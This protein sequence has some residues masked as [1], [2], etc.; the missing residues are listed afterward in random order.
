MTKIL[1]AEDILNT[2]D[3][4]YVIVPVPQWKGSVRLKTLTAGE[5]ME[6]AKLAN[7]K[8][9]LSENLIVHLVSKSAVDEDGKLLFNKEQ[10]GKLIDK[11]FGAF[12]IIQEA[13]LKLNGLDDDDAV[14]NA[15]N[16]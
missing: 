8:D 9:K 3:K 4:E 7:K 1:T 2:D 14:E 10:S 13:A 15:K 6:F 11:N 12:K 16:D 5:A